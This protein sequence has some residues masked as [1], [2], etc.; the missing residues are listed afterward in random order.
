MG[1]NSIKFFLDSLKENIEELNL[2]D[3]VVTSLGSG[4]H[5]NDYHWTIRLKNSKT[6]EE[7]N[8]QIP[9]YKD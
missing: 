7:K 1:F 5:D 6:R 3:W 4:R 9:C 2:D 8:I